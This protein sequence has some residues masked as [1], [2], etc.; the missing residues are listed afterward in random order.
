[1]NRLSDILSRDRGAIANRPQVNNL[2]HT[3]MWKLRC[4]W[5][6]G[7]TGQEACPTSGGTPV[8]LGGRSGTAQRRRVAGGGRPVGGAPRT[9]QSR[10]VA[11]KQARH[12]GLDLSG[13]V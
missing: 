12:L 5:H 7:T 2:P 8:P 6:I 11:G 13:T 9:G 1:M 10:H 4:V 3:K